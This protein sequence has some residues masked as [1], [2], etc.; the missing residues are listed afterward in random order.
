MNIDVAKEKMKLEIDS[1]QISVLGMEAS[2][3]PTVP[4]SVGKNVVEIDAGDFSSGI[5]HVLFASSADETRPVLTGVLLIFTKEKLTFVAT[6]GFRLSKKT[7]KMS[8]KSGNYQIILPKGALAEVLR[9]AGQ[10]KVV[11]FSYKKGS[12]QVIFGINDIVLSSRIIQGEFPDFE[13]IIPS[14]SDILVNIDKEELLRAVKVS[15][16]FARDSANSI[17]L[18]IKNNVSLSSKSAQAGRQEVSV[19]AK[20]EGLGKK[21]LEIAYNYRF[22]EEFLTTVRG[23]TVLMKFNSANAP[24]VFLDPKDKDY[25]H[26][27]MPVKL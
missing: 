20:V 13:K 8:K 19:D 16:V 7:I 17:M 3:F 23:E 26:L 15:G 5:G 27:I 24:G 9:L 14:S 1:Y 11:S 18:N 12:S 10:A 21:G 22:V 4:S 25:L 2:D 6:D